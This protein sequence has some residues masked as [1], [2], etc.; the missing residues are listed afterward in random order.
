MNTHRWTNDR[1]IRELAFR[2]NNGGDEQALRRIAAVEA[3][4]AR[5]NISFAPYRVGT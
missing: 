2:A 1:V 5:R 4:A 3:E